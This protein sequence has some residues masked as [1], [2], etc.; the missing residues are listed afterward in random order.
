MRIVDALKKI[1]DE[2]EAYVPSALTCEGL[3]D[4]DE[5]QDTDPTGT[6]K[7]SLCIYL[8]NRDSGLTEET[9]QVLV[10]LQLHGVLDSKTMTAYA[11]IVDE[12]IRAHIKPELIEMTNLTRINVECYPIQEDLGTSFVFLTLDFTSMADDC[13]YKEVD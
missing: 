8:V 9:L 11:D 6:D 5:Y 7:K 4:F 2:L 12:Q 3:T 1:K 10:Q 13:Y